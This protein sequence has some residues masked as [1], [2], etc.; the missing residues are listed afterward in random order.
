MTSHFPSL[1]TLSVSS[2]D[3]SRLEHPLLLDSLVTLTLEQNAFGSLTS[4]GP[5]AKLPNLR[6]L[7]LRDNAISS[8]HASKISTS[9]DLVA[10]ELRFSE[11]LCYVD[12]SYNAIASW[13]FIDDLQAVFP[14]LTG[15][16]VAHNPLYEDTA[17]N[18]G[19]I[20][21]VDEG[22]MLTLARLGNLKNLNFSSVSDNTHHNR[23]MYLEPC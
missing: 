7:F 17:A 1:T 18:D 4:L 16:R 8:I 10:R 3:F 21:G 22:Y 6:S 2:N 19:K 14:G 20:M 5:L 12:L 9:T 23:H 13:S 11:C 15:L